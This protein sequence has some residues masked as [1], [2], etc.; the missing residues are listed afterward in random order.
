MLSANALMAFVPLM[1]KNY[2]IL[3]FLKN[4]LLPITSQPVTGSWN[5]GL[6][7]HALGKSS[8]RWT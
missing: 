8:G 5:V 7:A 3:E 2:S 4:T 1:T 6:L